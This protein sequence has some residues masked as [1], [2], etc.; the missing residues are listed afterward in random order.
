[1]GL[2]DNFRIMSFEDFNYL[3]YNLGDYKSFTLPINQVLSRYYEIIHDYITEAISIN[4]LYE[5]SNYQ[6]E[7]ENLFRSY[8]IFHDT[9]IYDDS[10]LLASSSKSPLVMIRVKDSVYMNEDLISD[11]LFKYINNSLPKIYLEDNEVQRHNT[12]NLTFV[13]FDLLRNKSNKLK[14]QSSLMTNLDI[15]YKGSYLSLSN[16][17]GKKQSDLAEFPNLLY[18][19]KLNDLKI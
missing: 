8:F 6:R 1:M 10:I 17:V 16:I 12:I 14:Y 19:T 5:Y 13:I 7:V 3:S 18:I 11:I 2:N 15:S 9:D 4:E